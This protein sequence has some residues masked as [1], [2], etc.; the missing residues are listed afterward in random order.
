MLTL[1][2][3]MQLLPLIV[4]KSSIRL[5]KDG[6]AI[7]VFLNSSRGLV[8]IATMQESQNCEPMYL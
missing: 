5:K 4:S 3:Y 2:S 7:L 1:Q 6:V 8:S